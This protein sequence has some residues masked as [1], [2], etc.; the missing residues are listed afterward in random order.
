[1]SEKTPQSMRRIV[2]ARSRGYCEYCC[3]SEQF[4]TESFTV[5]HIK[6]RQAG[7]ET[8]LE[9]LAWSCFGCNGHKHTKMQALD[10]ETGEKIALYNPR[11][12]VWSEHFSWSDDFIQVIGKT[13]YGRATVEALRLNRS[14]VVNLRRLLRNASLHPPENV[15]SD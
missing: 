5:E 8:V 2:A 10:P 3:C 14:G 7:G 12:Q 1:M 4:A 6:P 15:E 9:N 13:A 11:Q